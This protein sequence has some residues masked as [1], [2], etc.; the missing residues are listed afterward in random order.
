M[1]VYLRALELGDLERCHKWHND[2]A[3]YQELDGSF[4]FVSKDVE[5]SWLREKCR[6]SSSEINLAICLKTSRE[7]IGNIYLRHINWI[8]RNAN[9]HILIGEKKNR[10]KGYGQSAIRQ[11]L[12]YAFDHLNLKRVYL[13]VLADNKAA[14]H[15]YQKCGFKIEGTMHN[16]VFKNGGW[17]NVIMMG[18][19]VEDFTSQNESGQSQA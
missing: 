13:E 17:K 10:A 2:M 16:H 9:L 14:T 18:I 15:V 1:P 3:L 5:E 12:S 19:C 8:S 6:S 7:H 11:L 4:H